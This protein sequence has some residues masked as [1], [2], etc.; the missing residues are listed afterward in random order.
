MRG[1]HPDGQ[2][3]FAHLADPPGRQVRQVLRECPVALPADKLF[4]Q[5]E[6]PALKTCLY[7]G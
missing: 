7:H 3:L 4:N 6:Q 1:K 2:G 5:M